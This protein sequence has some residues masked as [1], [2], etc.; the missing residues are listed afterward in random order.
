MM[1]LIGVLLGALMAGTF[2]EFFLKYCKLTQ[3]AS[4]LRNFHLLPTIK[5]NFV[6]SISN[7][8]FRYS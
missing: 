4:V 8:T 2:S 7:T 6:N 5:V 1:N 3:T